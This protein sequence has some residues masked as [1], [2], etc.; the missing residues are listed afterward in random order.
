MRPILFTV[1]CLATP[2]LAWG[3]CAEGLGS[4]AITERIQHVVAASQAT[5]VVVGVASPELGLRVA[6]AG[7]D[8]A[9]G[10]ALLTDAVFD[11][12]S[13]HK[14]VTALLVHRVVD[15][16]MLEL[17]D[18]VEE[19]LAVPELPG[20][21]LRD[22]L[23][24]SAGLKPWV[25]TPFL[26]KAAAD[27]TRAFTYDEM[28]ELLHDLDGLPVVAPFETGQDFVYSDYT[29]LVVSEVLVQ[30]F[31]TDIR[32][33][34]RHFLLL[35]LALDHTSF[36]AFDPRP[37]TLI[38][39][40]YANGAPHT[41]T[42]EYANTMAIA[43]GA[44]GSLLFTDACDLLQL[45]QATQHDRDFLSAATLADIA[46]DPVDFTATPGGPEDLGDV[47]AGAIRYDLPHRPAFDGL[48]GHL[49]SSQHGHSSAL[50]HDTA[51]GVT[52]VVLANV[53]SEGPDASQPG[54]DYAVHNDVL[55]QLRRWIELGAP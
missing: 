13:I 42:D 16:G 3:Q 26:A 5:A 54:D 21:T 17:D 40:Y 23:Q 39:G 24:H 41:F 18:A 14:H 29:P 43:S 52:Y 27:L 48:W 15:A 6:A 30:T 7:V 11:I 38:A 50:L 35:P 4:D 36:Q 46:S 51:A 12:G 20:A 19:T 55:T 2:A 53:A 9:T 10:E 47:A 37:D 32:T 25:Q 1:L 22:L 44:G 8:P 45:G 28:M 34:M 33:L 31:D 49:G